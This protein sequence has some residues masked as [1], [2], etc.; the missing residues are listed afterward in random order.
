MSVVTNTVNNITIEQ[1][2]QLIRLVGNE[3]N[4]GTMF[5]GVIKLLIAFKS[6]APA[7][8]GPDG[9]FRSCVWT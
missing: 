5:A 3:S 1:L 4:P 9:R 8:F 2:L 7:F 6:L